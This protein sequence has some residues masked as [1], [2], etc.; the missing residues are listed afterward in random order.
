MF[1]AS[2]SEGPPSLKSLL[3]NLQVPAWG[4]STN[5]QAVEPYFYGLM[6]FLKKYLMQQIS[7]IP[8]HQADSPRSTGVLNPGIILQS[9]CLQLPASVDT[10]GLTTLSEVWKAAA[11]LVYVVLTSFRLSQIS[12]F[13]PQLLQISPPS[14]WTAMDAG[15][16]P[17]RF[18]SIIPG[19]RLVPLALLLLSPSSLS[20]LS[21]AL[22]SSIWIR[23]F[24][25]SNQGVLSVFAWSSVRTAASLDVLD[26]SVERGVPRFHLPL[27]HLVHPI[28]A[29]S[30]NEFPFLLSNNA[31]TTDV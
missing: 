2:G 31:S 24:L 28:C 12:E 22:T 29:R 9:P 27:H 11:W 21:I 26:A 16:S 30:R 15:I 18:S 4:K 7:S 8:S 6:A 13:T 10:C 20:I 19:C 1:S 23:I 3:L 5:P 14:Q 17:L 25:L